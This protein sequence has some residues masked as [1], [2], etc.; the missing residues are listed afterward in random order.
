MKTKR[1]TVRSLCATALLAAFLAA[2]GTQ[3]PPAAELPS[4]LGQAEVLLPGF[5]KPQKVVFIF[6]AQFPAL[7]TL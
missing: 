5:E 2:C 7:Y 1:Y 3:T 4:N 6:A